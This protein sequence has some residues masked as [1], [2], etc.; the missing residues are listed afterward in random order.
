MYNLFDSNL[1]IID[2][3][4]SMDTEIL[5]K[6]I[7]ELCEEKNISMTTAFSKSGVGKNFKSNLKYANPSMGKLTMLAQYFEV[8]VNYLLGKTDQKENSSDNGGPDES[9]MREMYAN[10]SALSP[11]R[12]RQL[13]N[14]LAFLLSQQDD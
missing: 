12:R 10:Y 1:V 8:S 3:G 14:Y 5:I 4:V 2:G 7:K 6:R 9:K 11:E 13:D